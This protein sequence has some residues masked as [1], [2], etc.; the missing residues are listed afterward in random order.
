MKAEGS[1]PRDASE[2]ASRAGRAANAGW[3]CLVTAAIGLW[4]IASPFVLGLFDAATAEGFARDVTAERGLPAPA[5]RGML[6]GLNDIAAGLA[7]VAISLLTWQRRLVWGPWVIAGLGVWLLMAPLVFWA[8]T[9]AGYLNDTAAGTLVIAFA[10]VVTRPP[11]T[12][13]A[14]LDDPTDVPQGWTYTPSSYLQRLPIIVLATICVLFALPM[15]AY[16]LGHVGGVFDPFF[17]GAD[18]LNGTET[19]LRS[20]VSK[21]IPISDAGL[22]VIAYLFEVLLGLQGG[23]RRWR[24]SPWSVAMF[25]AVV[26]PLGVVSIS[27]IIIQPIVIGTYCTFCLITAAAMLVMIPFA[28]DEVLATGQFLW[29]SRGRGRSLI[30]LFFRGGTLDGGDVGRPR[31]RDEPVI[32][33]ALHEMARGV[34]VPPTLLLA[35][36]VGTL[37]MLSPLLIGAA[38]PLSGTLHLVGAL[39]ITVSVIAM[40]EPFRA[41]RWLDVPLGLWLIASPW[42]TPGA[43]LAASSLAVAAGLALVLLAVPHGRHSAERFGGRR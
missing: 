27:F 5:T 35:V 38:S 2:R 37:S 23:R 24:T 1:L 21:A 29:R 28:V 4:L 25:G 15:T 40:A 10:V 34:S 20:D 18:G 30:A 33:W 36:V 22:G 43:T 11:G 19:I 3:P 16:Q 8:P 9:L 41:L 32:G 31:P 6:V 26:V 7:I 12:D 14:A 42:L 13:R 17:A 39:A